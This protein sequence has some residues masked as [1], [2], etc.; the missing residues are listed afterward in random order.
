MRYLPQDSSVIFHKTVSRSEPRRAFEFFAQTK[1]ER[2]EVIKALNGVFWG[3]LVAGILLSTGLYFTLRLFLPQVRYFGR[4]LPNLLASMRSKGKVTGFGA[5]CAALGGQVGA[6]SLVGVAT[7]LASGGPGALF[8]MWVTALLGM[9]ISFVEAVL[10]QLFREKN[11]DGTYRGGPAYY[12]EKGLKCKWLAVCFSISVIIGIGFFYAMIQANSIVNA[13]TGMVDVNPLYPGLV[14]VALVALIVF[15]GVKRIADVSTYL[16]PFMALTYIAIAIFIVCMNIDKLPD[17]L[18]LIFSSAFS[19]EAA[20]GG[21][22]GHTIKEAFRYGIARGLFSNDAGNGTA[23]SM[24]AAAEVKHPVNQG[25][26]AMFGTFVTTMIICSCTGFCILFTG[27]LGTGTTGIV[28][29]QNTFTMGLGSSAGHL[30]VFLAMFLFAFTTLLGDIYYGEVNLQW[31]TGD[32][33]ILI[34]V[35]RVICCGLVIVGAISPVDN[36]WELVDLA[37]ASLVFFNVIALWG[38]GRYAVYILQDFERQKKNGVAEPTWNYE[39]NIMDM[40]ITKPADGQ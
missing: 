25:L 18:S 20:V 26:A 7:A 36:L 15:G 10:A 39:R 5:L 38:L 21:V 27:A 12:M 2:M 31:L 32:R 14:V 23:P 1:G 19:T 16:V 8:W 37:A 4:L 22:A 30:I 28:L 9:P 3:W 6:G 24:H 33:R 34:Q 11:K 29:T 13:F 35:F 17:V 40:D